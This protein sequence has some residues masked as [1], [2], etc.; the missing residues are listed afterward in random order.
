MLSE[1]EI[2]A[3]EKIEVIPVKFLKLSIPIS[4]VDFTGWLMRN[5]PEEYKLTLIH[6][7]EAKENLYKTL[8]SLISARIKELEKP[9]K[10]L[11]NLGKKK[12]G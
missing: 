8:D 10:H 9:R 12:L 4:V 6:L 3:S 2:M 11:Q 7:V 1:G 5:L